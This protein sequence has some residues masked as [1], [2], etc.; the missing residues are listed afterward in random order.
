MKNCVCM[1]MFTAMFQ[2]V[3]SS[4]FLFQINHLPGTGFITLKVELATSKLKWIPQ[5]F[6]MPKDKDALL[7]D[8]SHFLFKT[9]NVPTFL[10]KVY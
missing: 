4:F 10:T 6:E 5:A 9:Y 3:G 1:F 8:V 7:K 2:V